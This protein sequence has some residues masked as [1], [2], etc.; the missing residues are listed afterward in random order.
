V[1]GDDAMQGTE[2]VQADAADGMQGASID[3]GW[4]HS[5]CLYLRSE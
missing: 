3:G 2:G 1:Q 4:C 5:T